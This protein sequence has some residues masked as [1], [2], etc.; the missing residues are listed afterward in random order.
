MEHFESPANRGALERPDLV[1]KGSLDGFPPFVTVYLRMSGERV[2][3]ATF[4]ADGCGI[5]IACGSILTELVKGRS[6]V[7]CR[8]ITAETLAKAL[9]G[10][11]IEKEYCAAVAISALHDAIRNWDSIH[12][13]TLKA[14]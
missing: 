3:D 6:F 14:P 9:D 13:T 5:T 12:E 8:Q 2:A 4:V 1:G 7:E 10:I 11:P